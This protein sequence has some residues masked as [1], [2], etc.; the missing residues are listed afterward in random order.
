VRRILSVSGTRD[1]RLLVVPAVVLMAWVAFLGVL[2]KQ[3]FLDA[4][5]LV[6]LNAAWFVSQGETIYV[7]FFENH[8]PLTA[9][10]LQ[11]VVRSSGSAEVLIE[12]GR[13]LV[14]LLA[15]AIL[16]AVA[17][18]AHRVGGLLATWTASMLLAGHT[19]FVQKT[20]EI[21]PD[22]PALLLFC[23]ALCALVRGVGK[24]SW[25]GPLLAGALL[26]GA[27]LF[28]P[29]LIYAAAGACLAAA[30]VAGTASP[31]GWRD[32]ARLLGWILLGGA[33]VATLA[34][35]EMARQ[36]I[37]AG[38]FADAVLQSLRIT[39]DDPGRF[40][41]LYLKTTAWVDGAL[42][43]VAAAG[44]LIAWRRSSPQARGELWILAGSFLAGGLGLF[45]ISAPMRQVFLP[46]LPAAAVF[47]SL[48]LVTGAH[49]IAAR[50]GNPAAAAA[51]LL[52]LVAIAA[53]PF[54]HLR[55]TTPPM[56]RQLRILDQ[57]LE[58]SDPGDR[59]FDCFS[60]L[61]LTRLHAHRYF[62]LNSDI[63]RLFAPEELEQSVSRALEDPAVRLVLMDRDCRRLP[64]AVQR[65]I[66][67]RF[68]PIRGGNDFIWARKSPT[69]A[70]AP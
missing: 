2:G 67:N 56:D 16:L 31:R 48:G 47:G 59:V 36:G 23:L 3:R 12:R 39:I 44:A 63:Q 69:P 26:C 8:P 60:G 19:F 49:A 7:D 68:A 51:L 38:F 13:T 17:D 66:R 30:V 27:G 55:R 45:L 54:G 40:R 57:V 35:A 29:K 70:P 11:P 24:R 6:H 9:L 64:A 4:D 43:A 37:L 61:Y 21:R 33:A 46:L 25:G 18:L 52:A 15:F 10:L 14:L 65:S 41:W 53:A 50:Y 1:A 42:W 5:E 28:T 32:G 22:V 62:Y 58:A 20:L 34:F